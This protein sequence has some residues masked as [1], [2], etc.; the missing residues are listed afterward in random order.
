M[1]LIKSVSASFLF[2]LCS[3]NLNAQ[4]INN[5]SIKSG[6][7]WFDQNGKVVSAHGANIIKDG[8]KFYLFGEKHSDTSNAFAG[9]TCYSSTD[10]YNWIDEGIALNV[11]PSGR[12]GP[13]RVGERA[14]VMKCLKTGE[15]IMLMHTDT[16]GYKDPCI[17]YA[18]AKNIKGP[19]NFKGALLFNG[20][21]IRKWDMGTFQDTDGAGYLLIHS[22][23]IYK[24]SDDYKNITEEVIDN[25]WK[26]SESPA[27]FKKDNI[28]YWLVSDLT[29]WERNDNVYYTATSLKGPWKPMSYFA[30]EGS[31]TW[32][33]QTT[34]V[35]PIYGSKQTTYMFMGDR[36]SYPLQAS[37]ATYVWQP[38]TFAGDAISIPD[39]FES[40]K[41]NTATGIV[42]KIDIKGKT[43]KSNDTEFV[44]Y[45]GNWKHQSSANNSQES[46]SNDKDAQISFG[47]TGSEVYLYG[48]ATPTGGYAN[49]VIKDD[50]GKTVLTSV[51]D[52]YCKYSS[53]GLRFA[54]PVLKKGNYTIL[55]TV[56]GQHSKWSDKRKTDYGST[57][58]FVSVEKF[59]VN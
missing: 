51:I 17:G 36:W 52:M 16:L 24:L 57:G 10:L 33:S 20:N 1:S 9:F 4:S 43:V 22:G 19:Y 45:S 5:N 42:N 26:G 38:V 47:F 13:N 32:N 21:P 34:F 53:T 59:I 37:A 54:S 25:N 18:T 30:P 23:L 55:L 58:N 27:I 31:L 48:N 15:Y 2:L 3:I 14:K 41:I 40:W 56:M 12:L 46:I 50:K 11:Q 7:P 28:Y 6:I 49:V 8:E 29:S 35:L 44:K 39:Y